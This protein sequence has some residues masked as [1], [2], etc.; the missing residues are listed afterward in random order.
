MRIECM[1]FHLLVVLTE[2]TAALRTGPVTPPSCPFCSLLLVSSIWDA[3]AGSLPGTTNTPVFS[4][5]QGA[6]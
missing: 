1:S 2:S 5:N 4:T 3:P 6:L